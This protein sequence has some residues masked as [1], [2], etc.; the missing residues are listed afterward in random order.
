M[1]ELYLVDITAKDLAS[2]PIRKGF[3]RG[4]KAAGEQDEN[5]VAACADLTD[6][7]QMSLFKEAF[8]DR[9]IEIG[10]AEQN[11]VT[12]GAGMAAMGKIPFV[13]SYAAFSPGRNWEQIRTTICLNDRPVKVVGSH[14]GVSVGPDGATHQMLEDIALMR[15]LP[16]MVVIV[17]GDSV[18][19]EKATLAMAK[20]GRPS[21]L[22]LAREATPI[23]T[24]AKTPFVIG[25]AYVYAPGTDVTIIATGTMT[26]QALLAA[27]QLYKDGID[28]EVVHVPTI[29]PLDTETIL[30]SVRKTGC[31][32]TVEEGQ[33][34]GGLG[35]AIAEL[36]GEEHPVPMRRIGMKDRFGESGE[37]NELLEYFGLDAKHIR[38]AAHHIVEKK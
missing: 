13:S 28:A 12:V 4:L 33:I 21:Y 26:Y 10:V 30:K 11:L 25:K 31:V 20:D 16:N 36:L 23:I 14:A 37:P 35:G 9:F 2:E 38:L 8:P 17:P 27:E 19:A 7:T 15:V 3:G 32:V 5:V 29:K 1:S 34:A 18:E 6:S 24:T 22:R